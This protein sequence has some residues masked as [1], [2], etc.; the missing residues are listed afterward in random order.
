[1]L[2]KILVTLSNTQFPVKLI[3]FWSKNFFQE[4]DKQFRYIALELCQA[5]LQDVSFEFWA[6]FCSEFAL[7]VILLQ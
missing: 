5:T 3:C 6:F 4:E 2:T 1:M 7:L